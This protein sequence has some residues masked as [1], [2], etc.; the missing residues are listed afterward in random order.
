MVQ[1]LTP[2]K[3][4]ETRVSLTGDI[5]KLPPAAQSLAF[6]GVGIQMPPVT[7]QAQPQE[8]EVTEESEGLDPQSGVPVKRKVSV[9]GKPLS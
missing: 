2:P 5:T 9:V 6:E 7:L 3:T 1:K 8:H 4:L